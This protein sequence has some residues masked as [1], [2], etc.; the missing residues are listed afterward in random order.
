[1]N[2]DRHSS[3]PAYWTITREDGLL[4][5][6]PPEIAIGTEDAWHQAVWDDATPSRERRCRLLVAG[7]LAPATAGAVVVGLGDHRTW[8]RTPIG[9]SHVVRQAARLYVT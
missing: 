5:G 8:T 1:M 6:D 3:E 9:A 4:N 2:L 7:P